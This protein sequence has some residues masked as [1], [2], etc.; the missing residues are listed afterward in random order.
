MRAWSR[1][2]WGG[3]HRGNVDAHHC[4]GMWK[5]LPDNSSFYQQGQLWSACRDYQQGNNSQKSAFHSNCHDKWLQTDVWER[6]I[7]DWGQKAQLLRNIRLTAGVSKVGIKMLAMEAQL[8]VRMCFSFTLHTCSSVAL[9]LYRWPIVWRW[10][11]CY[12]KCFSFALHTWPSVALLRGGGPLAIKTT[13]ECTIA[14]SLSLKRIFGRISRPRVD[15]CA[16][17]FKVPF[18]WAIAL[19][20]E[21]FVLHI[22]CAFFCQEF[23][24]NSIV[25]PQDASPSLI[26]VIQRGFLRLVKKMKPGSTSDVKWNACER[27]KVSGEM[28]KMY[29]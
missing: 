28:W 25:V 6:S 8:Q 26:Y 24:P 21:K 20:L 23:P 5:G 19:T 3:F 12:Q 10:T 27:W 22:T 2:S 11:A 9:W 17:L 1:H 7:K 13:T 15:W 18:E 16:S 14:L 29:M 4:L